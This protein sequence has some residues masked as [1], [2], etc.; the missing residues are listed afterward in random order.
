MDLLE[1]LAEEK[2]SAA[3]RNGDLDNLPGKG[4]ALV[5][6]DLSLVPEELRAAY[7]ILKNSGFVPPGVQLR[8]DLESAEAMLAHTSCNQAREGQVRRI[9]FMRTQLGLLNA[10][11]V[12]VEERYGEALQTQ[13]SRP[14]SSNTEPETDEKLPTQIVDNSVD[15]M[16]SINK[17]AG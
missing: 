15:R 12:D 8:K 17:K 10:N 16:A 1:R 7:L 2:I 6:E 13:L 14:G 5:L 9:Q 11:L 4:E 3:I